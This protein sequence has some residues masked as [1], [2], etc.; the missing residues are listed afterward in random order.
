MKNSKAVDQFNDRWL[1]EIVYINNYRRF[2]ENG[3]L[4]SRYGVSPESVTELPQ[5]CFVQELAAWLG[6]PIQ[7]L[8]NSRCTM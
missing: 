8:K 3:L 4:F 5:I 7:R 6:K 2:N 1:L